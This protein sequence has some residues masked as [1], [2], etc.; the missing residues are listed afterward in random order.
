MGVAIA[1]FGLLADWVNAAQNFIAVF[2]YVYVLVIFVYVISTMVRLP[3]SFNAV[4]RF[5]YDVCE[6]YLR[7]FRRILPSLG[8]ID[9]SPFVAT[10]VLIGVEQLVVRLLDNAH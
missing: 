3:Y 8:P 6:P 2:T 10:I 5:L 7:I 9:L 4:Q 1:T